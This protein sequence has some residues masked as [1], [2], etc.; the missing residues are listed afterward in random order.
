MIY[1]SDLY[2]V[3]LFSPQ[4]EK[5]TVYSPRCEEGCDV[6]AVFPLIEGV[7]KVNRVRE[8]A[9]CRFDSRQ[10]DMVKSCFLHAYLSFL[11]SRICEYVCEY[12]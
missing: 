4:N 6:G 2:E 8:S 11:F 9:T 3:I 5:S 10:F 12:I 1:G 7:E